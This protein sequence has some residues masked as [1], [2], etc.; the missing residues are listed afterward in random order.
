MA[1]P[2]RLVGSLVA[3]TALAACS[4]NAPVP[5][6]TAAS[7]QALA[8]SSPAASAD[9]AAACSDFT[10]ARD[11]TSM[12]YGKVKLSIGTSV[13]EKATLADVVAYTGTMAELAAVCAPEAAEA[14]AALYEQTRVFADAYVANADPETARKLFGMLVA[15]RPVG[16]SA[17]RAMGLGTQ[18]WEWLP[19]HDDGSTT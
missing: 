7:Q 6:P 2:L 16:E 19:T 3:W 14:L 17:W 1:P 9:S 15:V 18:G 12:K 11:R 8:S 10:S 5:L 13:D 4:T